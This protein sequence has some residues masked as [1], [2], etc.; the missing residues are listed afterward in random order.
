M[1]NSHIALIGNASMVA[2]AA[3]HMSAGIEIGHN[4]SLA[5]FAGI[6]TDEVKALSTR[7]F[8]AGLFAVRTSEVSLSKREKEGIDPNT[9]EPYLPMFS[10][11]FK[12]EI[13]EAEPLDKSVNAESLVGRHVTEERTFWPNDLLT[14]I[15]VLKGDYLKVGLNPTGHLGGLE[16]AEPGWVDTIVDHIFPLKVT[17]SKPNAEGQQR[18]RISWQ[19]SQAQVPAE[20]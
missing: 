6:E 5:D 16:G 10:I 8:P 15:G 2:F 17:H 7:L 13:L 3:M 12:H 4:M 20:A 14:E 11:I 1:N 19:K 18:L 9:G